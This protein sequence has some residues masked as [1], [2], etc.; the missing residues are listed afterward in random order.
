PAPLPSLRRIIH[1]TSLRAAGSEM[2]AS[3]A[4]ALLAP[5]LRRPSIAVLTSTTLGSEVSSGGGTVGAGGGALWAAA[6]SFS[7][8]WAFLSLDLTGGCF[9]LLSAA[10]AV[11]ACEPLAA[12]AAAGS[13]VAQQM[14]ATRLAQ[15][16][17]ATDADQRPR[18]KAAYPRFP[19]ESLRPR[20]SGAR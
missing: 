6:S 7:F 9:P 8:L 13:V 16:S 19:G 20:Y 11:A 4:V 10:F 12:R 1:S 2:V 15:A 14:T 3:I 17:A 18:V 5:P